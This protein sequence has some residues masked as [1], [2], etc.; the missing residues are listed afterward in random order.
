MLYRLLSVHVANDGT[1]YPPGSYLDLDEHEASALGSQAVP[2]G[3]GDAGIRS[4]RDYLKS[5]FSGGSQWAGPG[6]HAFRDAEL[7]FIL[8]PDGSFQDVIGNRGP[9]A[10][11]Q[12]LAHQPYFPFRDARTLD[13]WASG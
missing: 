8:V 6:T 4:L 5:S 2:V 13:P 3:E 9:D 7:G 11:R 12:E 10:G 1:R